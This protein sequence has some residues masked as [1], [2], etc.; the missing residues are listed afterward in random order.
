MTSQ[1]HLAAAE[2]SLDANHVRAQALARASAHLNEL[3][4]L[5]RNFLA[6][7]SHELRTPLTAMLGFSEV[8]LEDLAGALNPEQASFVRTIRERGEE[9]LSVISH[10]LE[11]SEL[12][13]GSLGLELTSCSIHPLLDRAVR[14]V[15]PVAAQAST[16]IEIATNAAEAPRVLVDAR[17]M[18]QVVEKLLANAVKFSTRGGVVQVRVRTGPLRR[19]L[20]VEARFGEEAHDALVVEI[21][22][23]GIGIPDEELLRIFEPFYQVDASSTRVHGGTGLGLSIAKSLIGAHGGEVWASSGVGEGTVVSFTVP[24]AAANVQE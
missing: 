7:V 6:T 20:S 13:V 15:S 18:Q 10:I 2:R 4:T 22:D 23:N 5:K 19:P 8:L 14:R 9:L 17:K 11:M 12:E 21:E 24:L 1:V 16:R 3:D